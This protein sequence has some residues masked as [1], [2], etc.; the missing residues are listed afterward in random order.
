MISKWTLI[1]KNADH[2]FA[3]WEAPDGN[4]HAISTDAI[5]DTVIFSRSEGRAKT[6]LPWHYR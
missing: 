1:A 2:G 3:E 5:L 6:L 4:L